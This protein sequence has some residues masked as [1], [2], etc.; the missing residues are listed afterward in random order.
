MSQV[1]TNPLLN[2]PKVTLN[3]NQEILTL[4]GVQVPLNNLNPFIRQVAKFTSEQPNF[5]SLGAMEKILLNFDWR[6]TALSG[7]TI[8]RY[9]ID[10]DLFRRLGD[11]SSQFQSFAQL[12]SIFLSI[13]RSDNAFYAG[14]LMAVYFP[15]PSE[16]YLQT[17]FGITH[18]HH[19]LWQLPKVLI[20]PKTSDDIN[21]MINNTWPFEFLPW[22]VKNNFSQID[23][24]KMGYLYIAVVSPL[25]TL[26][27]R[28][29][30]NYRLSGKLINLQTNQTIT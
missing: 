7:S 8:L 5:S 19:H 14:L 6:T 24:Y 29:S 18:T 26:A 27:P 16:D 11:I 13:K 17:F 12:D 30:L 15:Y 9:A 1:E 20:S 23:S 10:L 2:A 28:N 4:D 3:N 25:I 22:K 21:M